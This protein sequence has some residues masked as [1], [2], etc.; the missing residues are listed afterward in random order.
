MI[1]VE[2]PGLGI[3]IPV[4][5]ETCRVARLSS[6]LETTDDTEAVLRLLLCRTA[7]GGRPF[8]CTGV[9]NIPRSTSNCRFERSCRPVLAL[10]CSGLALGGPPLAIKKLSGDSGSGKLLFRGV[11]SLSPPPP[12]MEILRKPKMSPSDCAWDSSAVRVI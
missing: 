5:D 6:G 10:H 9:L 7:M 11:Y 8:P 1:Y 4:P 3:E 12:P 2:S